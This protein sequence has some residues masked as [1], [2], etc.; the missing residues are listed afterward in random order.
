M[1]LT[2]LGGLCL[3]L[4]LTACEG[5]SRSPAPQSAQST[6]SAQSA[7]PV[8]RASEPALESSAALPGG[9]REATLPG[10]P[11]GTQVFL[12]RPD[13]G[14]RDLRA[15]ADT[16]LDV[17]E[18]DARGAYSFPEAP[19]LGAASAAQEA[20][21]VLV[22]AEGQALVRAPW[23]GPETRVTLSPEARVEVVVRAAGGPAELAFALVLDAE[24]IPLPVPVAPC[25]SDAGGA[26][27]V[28]RLPAGR[29]ELLIASPDAEQMARLELDLA[30]G[31]TY[32]REV[33]LEEDD[34][35][36]RR[37]LVIA[38]GPQVAS[39]IGADQ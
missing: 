10:A 16:I 7:A 26:L 36:T 18:P 34:A 28:T 30:G 13:A 24:G 6:E 14:A 9:R 8:E 27:V 17:S 15:L 12:V 22:S 3:A 5:G 39:A 11:A 37:F 38:G 32:R 35:L 4:T 33:T 31:Q 25:V 2:L 21:E 29:C 20:L 1:R 19:D 23:R